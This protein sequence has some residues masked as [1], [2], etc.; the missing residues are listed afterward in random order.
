MRKWALGFAAVLAVS[1]GCATLGR[2]SFKEPVVTFKD[3]RVTGLG[4]TGGS[5]E[6]V[7]DVHNPNHFRLDGTRLTYRVMVDSVPF[8]DGVFTDKFQVEEGETS[9]VR[10]PFSFSY[11]GV[12]AAGR[13]LM[14]TGSVEYH[15]LGDM[16]VQTPLGSFTRPYD[17]RGRFST[18][19]GAR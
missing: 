16:T 7:L 3:A 14:Q 2:S 4:V 6:I 15:V 9:T 12:G 17:Q 19:S 8:G 11:A 5:I 1:A 10:L 13:Q 18:L